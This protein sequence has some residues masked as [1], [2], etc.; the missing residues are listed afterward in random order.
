MSQ[1]IVFAVV[2]PRG[3]RGV[4]FERR[5][6][7]RDRG[8]HAGLVDDAGETPDPRATAVLVVPF[9]AEVALWRLRPLPR[10]FPPPLI[11]LV[12]SQ[13][14]GLRA[15]LVDHNKIDGNHRS[16]RPAAL[17]WLGSIA[18]KIARTNVV[19]NRWSHGAMLQAA[20]ER[21]PSDG[22]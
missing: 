16:A 3:D 21:E 8:G 12:T 4:E 10:V 18:N 15:F 13:Y 9:V 5:R 17:R 2:H 19:W 22:S 7:C 1:Q 20:T 11:A 14:G 6:G